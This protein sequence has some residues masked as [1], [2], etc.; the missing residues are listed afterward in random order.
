MNQISFSIA[1]DTHKKLKTRREKF[2]ELMDKLIPWKQLEEKIAKYY[3]KS[4]KGRRPYPL[5]CQR[6]YGFTACSCSTT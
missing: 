4:G 6:C 2:L 1:A 3:P 5:L